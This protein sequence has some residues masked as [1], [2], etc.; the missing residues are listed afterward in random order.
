MC[1][2][3]G[4]RLLQ[5]RRRRPRR[6]RCLI[7][8]RHLPFAPP[9]LEG[10][11]CLTRYHPHQFLHQGLRHY[12]RRFRSH[13]RR[14]Q[15]SKRFLTQLRQSRGPLPSPAALSLRRDR[16]RRRCEQRQKH[17]SSF[18]GCHRPRR[19]YRQPPGVQ[20]LLPNLQATQNYPSRHRRPKTPPPSRNG[21]RRRRKL[22]PHSQL[23]R[24]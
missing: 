3:S 10:C 1:G 7:H 9:L 2:C 5:T 15:R 8:L 17:H 16:C 21:S 12:N 18:V 4:L 19:H 6:R 13:P 23:Q 22:P 11:R 14:R 24:C 20:G